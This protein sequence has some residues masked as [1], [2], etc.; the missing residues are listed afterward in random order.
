MKFIPK[1]FVPI[2]FNSISIDDTLCSFFGERGRCVMNTVY[3]YPDLK[4][5]S[6]L[7]ITKLKI[8]AFFL[9]DKK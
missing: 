6:F 3:I 5:V 4:V 2:F 8:M 9:T 1:Q 7:P